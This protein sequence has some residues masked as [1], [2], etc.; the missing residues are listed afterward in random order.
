LGSTTLASLKDSYFD[1]LAVT[2]LAEDL[3]S[4]MPRKDISK[5]LKEDHRHE[6][7]G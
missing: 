5:K 7:L 2:R 1:V 3:F 4:R 6:E